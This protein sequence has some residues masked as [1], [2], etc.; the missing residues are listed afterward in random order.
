MPENATLFIVGDVDED[1][2]VEKVANRLSRACSKK[3][4]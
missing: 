2:A 3:G 4:G 1:I